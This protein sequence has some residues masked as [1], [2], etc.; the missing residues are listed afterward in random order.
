MSNCTGLRKKYDAALELGLR[1]VALGFCQEALAQGC[2]WAV[3]T[4]GT[5]KGITGPM[6]IA[7]NDPPMPM[8]P[9]IIG[10]PD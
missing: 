8:L 7:E 9:A 10:W 6:G 4:C 5:L 2:K 1:D 3:S